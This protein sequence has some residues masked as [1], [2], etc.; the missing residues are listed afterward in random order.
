MGRKLMLVVAA[1][2]LGYSLLSEAQQYPAVGTTAKQEKIAKA[3]QERIKE[4]IAATQVSAAP[5]LVTTIVY[6]PGAPAD[7]FY[8]VAQAGPSG[9]IGNRF[10]SDSGFALLASGT[11]DRF[12]FYPLANGSVTISLYGPLS[13]TAA[14]LIDLFGVS[15]VVN[16]VFNAAA[17]A[18]P[19][20]VGPSFLAGL[21]VG[22]WGGIED[23]IG[24]RNATTNGQG[25]HGMQINYGNISG[26]G[27]EALGSTNAMIRVHGNLRVPVE[28]MSFSIE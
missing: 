24:I 13:G 27:F 25:Y 21:Y 6:D 9:C 4:R 16:Y 11:I 17:L 3:R 2:L 5:D 26:T 15:G 10:N 1:I 19:M 23:S 12:T 8:G 20:A 28:L 7:A 14:P 18:T 22:T